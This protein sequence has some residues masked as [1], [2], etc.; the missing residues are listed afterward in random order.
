MRKKIIAGNWKMN[1]T[2]VEA[3]SLVRDLLPLV[4]DESSVDVVVCP[5]FTALSDVY[6]EIKGSKIALGAQDFFWKPSGAYTGQISAGM[7]LD[8]GATYVIIGHSERRGRFGV[9]EPDADDAFYKH[10]GDSDST[11]NR[12]AKAAL[13]NGLVPIICLGET[14]EERKV[15]ATDAVV[16][17]QAGAALRGLDPAAVGNTVVFAYEPVWAIGTGEVCD[18]EEAN[19]VCGVLRETVMEVCGAEA[20]QS[21]RIQYGGSMKPDNALEL[22]KK[23]NI[24]GG[25][26]GGASLKAA[27]FAKIVAAAVAA[28]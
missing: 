21:V 28:S 8:V 7:L 24:D 13:A 19:R 10:F 22:L 3:Q 12:K 25:L 18:A 26:I 17:S 1:K 5:P 9:P 4:G 20:A 2:V 16:H 15:G 14:L 11:V 23:E 27:D 6:R